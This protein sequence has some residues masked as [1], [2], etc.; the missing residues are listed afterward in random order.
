[1][2][3]QESSAPVELVSLADAADQL[4]VH[5][6][7]AYR[8]V[9]TGR[10]Y[11]T[12]RGGKWWVDPAEIKAVADP[13]TTPRTAAPR[14]M[15]AEPFA[16]RLL[17]GDVGGCW[18]VITDALRGG[19]TAPEV[20]LRLLQPALIEVGERWADGT[21]TIA[22]EHRATATANRLIGQMGPLFRHPGRR[23][24][25]AVIGA[26]AGDPHS[27]PSALLADLLTDRRLDVVDLGANTPAASFIE[28]VSEA[29]D[30]VGVGLCVTL[31][32]LVDDAVRE[33]TEIRAALPTT[34]LVAGGSVVSRH[35]DRFR[36]I[37]DQ[38]TA[39]AGEACDAFEAAASQSGGSGRE[40]TES[41]DVVEEHDFS[42]ALVDGARA[43]I[44]E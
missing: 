17:A 41:T 37:V 33:I 39:T 25:T 28:T 3:T 12:K 5:Y 36:P 6:M 42:E 11:A 40:T 4:G 10:M 7:T 29:D 2:S 38:V 14:E 27:I 1:M 24:G 44:E 23:R 26:T 34:M 21:I 31:E 43:G 35:A 22:A 18:D 9:R 13:D 8:Y 32:R 20:H 16:R 30:V 15:L 19:A